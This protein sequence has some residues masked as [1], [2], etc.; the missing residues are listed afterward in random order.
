[1]SGGHAHALHVHGHS[2]A[3]G[4]P[5][6]LKV[7]ALGL[8]VVAVVATPARAVWAFVVYA[9]LLGVAA[10]VSDIPIRFIVKRMMV[11]VPFLAFAMLLPFVGEAPHSE[12]LGLRVSEAGL[13]AAWT[14]LAKGTCG[15]VASILL[16]ATTEI[17][18]VLAGMSRLRVPKAIVAI[19]GF[20]VRYIEVIGGELARMRVAMAARGYEPKAFWQVKALATSAGALFIRSYERGERVYLA[21]VSRGY[22]GTMPTF[23]T[24]PT[25]AVD[26]VRALALP[27]LALVVAVIALIGPI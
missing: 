11:E 1:M 25:V 23:S 20:M 13:L 18:D 6:H 7:A 14:I 8:F 9:A 12:V 10:G 26:V 19:A 27:G 5:G 21:M 24:D 16:A 15:V 4:L 3:H 17:P 2:V 22:S